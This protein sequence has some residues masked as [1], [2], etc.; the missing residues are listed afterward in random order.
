MLICYLFFV[1]NPFFP[2]LRSSWIFDQLMTTRLSTGANTFYRLVDVTGELSNSE[3]KIRPTM[4]IHVALYGYRTFRFGIP[5][6]ISSHRWVRHIRFIAFNRV[7]V[8]RIFISLVPPRRVYENKQISCTNH[9][10]DK[11]ETHNCTD[12][13]NKR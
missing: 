9:L 1:Q 8:K 12:K 6:R 4:Q 3:K 10:V 2:R 11:Y 5:K 13:T 7:I